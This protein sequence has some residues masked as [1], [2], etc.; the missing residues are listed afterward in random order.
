MNNSNNV[1]IWLC[2]F[3]LFFSLLCTAENPGSVHVFVALCDND[4]QGIVPVPKTLGNGE[5][6]RNNLYWGAMYGT[7]TFL[8]KSGNWSLLSTSNTV[9]PHILERC[10][11]RHKNGKTILVADAYKGSSIKRCIADFLNAAAGKNPQNIKTLTGLAGIHGNAALVCY[12]GHNGLMDCSL[13]EPKRSTATPSKHVTDTIVLACK[14]KPYFE[15]RLARTG[16]RPLLLT[17]GF[18]APE[19]YTL[20]AALEGWIRKESGEQIRT[21]AAQAYNTYQKCG[22][23]G[24]LRLFHTGKANAARRNTK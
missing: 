4:S 20:E 19:A 15:N 6:P 12:I 11:F 14:S 3:G 18:M 5:D 16:A 23:R 24:A 8:K 7:K 21:R 1:K 17:T 2:L 22:M 9:S 10:V 13:P